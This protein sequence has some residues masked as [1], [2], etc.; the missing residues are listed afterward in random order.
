MLRRP[1][2]RAHS[3]SGYHGDDMTSL[4]PRRLPI[5]RTLL[6]LVVAA[7]AGYLLLVVLVHPSNERD[8]SPDQQRLATAEFSGESVQVH[9]VRNT[10][11][12]ST[13]D[14]D[15]HWEDRSYDLRRLESV[16]FVVEPFATWRGPAHT[17]LSFG[18]GHG[19]YVAISV[20]IRKEQGETFSP[21]RGLLRQYEL[22]YI[23]GDEHDLIGLRANH[24]H[25]DVHLYPTRITPEA[26]RTLF[27]SMLERANAIAAK[28]EL[29][30]TLSN[31][32]T[33]NIVDHVNRV[34][35]EPVRF[36][37]KI[38]LPAYSDDLAFDLGLIDTD[39]P[40]EQFRAAFRINDRARKH[41]DSAD[42]SEAIRSRT[43]D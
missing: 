10:F 37:Y 28:P 33:T 4:E 8:W 38:V 26:A 9:N 27:V 1:N 12:R 25:D 32:C 42:F 20:E 13:T 39:L 14:Y 17:F 40:R 22:T 18:F 29:Y 30:N 21:L 35:P 43:S 41:A 6:A 2:V 23:V 5:R 31:T 19:E 36:S 34:A 24:R 7:I 16:W 3:D 15:V 11:Y